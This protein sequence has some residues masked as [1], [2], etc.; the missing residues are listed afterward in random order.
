V[1]KNIVTRAW[2]RVT[3]N[4]KDSSPTCL[5]KHLTFG[6]IGENALISGQNPQKNS[7]F[8]PKQQKQSV[9]QGHY[10]SYF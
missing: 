3:R 5:A 6:Q 2:H 1:D 9:I 4:F 10:S 8:W 7:V